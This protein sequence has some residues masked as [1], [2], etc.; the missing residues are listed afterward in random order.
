MVNISGDDFYMRVFRKVLTLYILAILI[1]LSGCKPTKTDNNS[2]ASITVSTTAETTEITETV[3][4]VQ[5]I[6]YIVNTNTG[7]FHYPDCPIVD[8]MIEPNKL[9]YSGNKE[10]L[11]EY[12]YTPCG[13]CNP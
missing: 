7:K 10:N 2:I 6:N 5:K 4:D 9:Y 3:P 1:T 12:G 11:L 13:R 8:Q